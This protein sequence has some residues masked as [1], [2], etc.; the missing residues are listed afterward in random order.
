MQEAKAAWYKQ[1]TAGMEVPLP[2]EVQWVNLVY[3]VK[4]GNP[5]TAKTV[6]HKCAGTLNS[7][8]SYAIMGPSGAGR[9]L[10]DLVYKSKN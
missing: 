6:I 8:E 9:F 4:I 3:R 2:V 1:A 5:P 7:C 10:Q